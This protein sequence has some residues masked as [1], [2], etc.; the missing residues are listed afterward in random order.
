MTKAI[1]TAIVV[2]L[3]SAAV[4][5]AAPPPARA[6]SAANEQVLLGLINAARS[7]RGLSRLVL[8][9]Y[10]AGAA[11]AH[12][13]DMLQHSYFAHS[14][15]SGVSYST[16][17]A[18]A[19]YRRSGFGPWA[20]SEVIGWGKG[21]RGTP[22]AVLRAWLASPWHRPIVLGARWR[23][24]GI[25]CARGAYQGRTGVLMYTVDV[26]RRTR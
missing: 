10:L 1:W 26:G 19:G 16:R 6:G 21:M 20:V 18:R 4:A 17:L 11:R 7:Q 8:Q 9:T 5:V 15:A 2:M 12:S 24:V 13:L 25:G 14:S 22:Q 3:V 23:D